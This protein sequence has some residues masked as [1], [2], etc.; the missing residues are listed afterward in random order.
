MIYF[1][2]ATEH[3]GIVTYL[4]HAHHAGP[5]HQRLAIE[6]PSSLGLLTYGA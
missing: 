1:F 6:T 4:V 2:N 5:F 3:F